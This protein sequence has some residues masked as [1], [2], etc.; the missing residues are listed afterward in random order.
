V[1]SDKFI[2]GAPFHFYFGIVKGESALDKFKAK[3]SINE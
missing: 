3:Y 1:S 2:V